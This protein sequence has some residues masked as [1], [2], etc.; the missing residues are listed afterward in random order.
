MAL[1]EVKNVTKIFGPNPKAALK[2]YREGLSKEELLAETGHTLGLADVSL[3]ITKGEIFVVM[4][5]SGSGKSTMIRHFN[6]LI[7]PT[8][9]QIL[10]N[11]DDVLKMSSRE[12][13]RFRRTKMSMVFQRFG[14]MPHRTVLQN[15][16]YG[17]S[18]RG[19]SKD[20]REERSRHWI[21]VVGLAGYENQ[22]PT[23]LSGG[24][25]QRVGLARALATDAEILLMD[26]A[27]SALDPLIRSQMQDQLIELQAELG[28]TIVFI[29]HDL[30]EALRIG[31]HI[32]I[33]KDGR[34]SQVGTPPEI[35]LNPA[36][37]YVAEFVR[38]VNRA[39]VLTVDTVMK[40]PKARIT[41]ENIERALEEMRR[42]GVQYGYV[43]DE[44]RYRGVASQEHLEA[45]LTDDAASKNLYHVVEEGPTLSADAA[46]E[47]ALPT[48]LETA[49]P[50]PV[51]DEGGK[52]MGV[53]SSREMS[54]VLSPP[55]AANE[56]VPDEVAPKVTNEDD[57]DEPAPKAT[58]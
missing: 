38:D 21:E 28:K 56:D 1:I 16:G 33:L 57:T 17:L 8:D 31:D 43:V 29:T 58:A 10:V 35:L 50:L 47:V 13:E 45:V 6:R 36:D 37:D 25:Q 12:L 20:E 54:S 23:Q 30:D 4:G 34:L 26:E 40:P 41:G 51:V 55:K 27:F 39:R 5:L 42:A 24:M 2:R 14:L 32:A 18:V 3:S 44:E 52:L 19:T 15:V 7:D 48:A 46:L 11:G 53:V 9:G 22:Y 49:Y